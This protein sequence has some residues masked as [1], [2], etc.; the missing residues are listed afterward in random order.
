MIFN[1]PLTLGC[2]P[3]K[4]SRTSC[5][6]LLLKKILLLIRTIR[7]DQSIRKFIHYSDGMLNIYFWENAWKKKIDWSGWWALTNGKSLRGLCTYGNDTY[8]TAARNCGREWSLQQVKHITHTEGL[9]PGSSYR[10][11]LLNCLQKETVLFIF[12]VPQTV[13]RTTVPATDTLACADCY[14]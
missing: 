6:L 12:L 3:F 9:F 1:K 13:S 10:D 2:L 4:S 14:R 11:K 7:S 5:P 8:C